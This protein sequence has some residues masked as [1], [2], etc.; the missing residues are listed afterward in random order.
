MPRLRA[1]SGPEPGREWEVRS[2]CVV[3]RSPGCWIRIE[4]ASVSREHARIAEEE[5]RW[6]L[7]DLESSNGTSVNGRRVQRAVLSGGDEIA[8]GRARLRFTVEAPAEILDEE[9]TLEGEPAAASAQPATRPPTTRPAPPPAAKEAPSAPAPPSPTSAVAAARL[10][11]GV[12]RIEGT[13]TLL[14]RSTEPP[15]SG[16]LRE[17]LGQRGF[18]FRL[19]ILLGLLVLAAG[20]FFAARALTGV[21]LPPAEEVPLDEGEAR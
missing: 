7:V 12:R 16:L 2:P 18:F 4:E 21:L 17:D 6:I 14:V 10:A 15:T 13:G 20:L 9:I 11:F 1:L 5:G 8:F 3:G 19:G